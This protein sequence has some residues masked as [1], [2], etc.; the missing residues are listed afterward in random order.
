M[1]KQPDFRITDR[2]RR[3]PIC[4]VMTGRRHGTIDG[5]DRWGRPVVIWDDGVVEPVDADE[6][7]SV[8]PDEDP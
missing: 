4:P 5:H 6:I 8:P 1:K 7:E 3:P 2:V